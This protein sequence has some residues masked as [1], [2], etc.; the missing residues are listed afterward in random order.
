M[1]I[2]NC[3]PDKQAATTSPLTNLITGTQTGTTQTLPPN[4]APGQTPTSTTT[5]HQQQKLAQAVGYPDDEDEKDWANTLPE[6]EI[7][8]HSEKDK[9]EARTIG[10][11]K[12]PTRKEIIYD[13]D[14]D[15]DDDDNDDDFVAVEGRRGSANVPQSQQT[16]PFDNIRGLIEI[17]IADIAGQKLD[18]KKAARLFNQLFGDN[19][20]HQIITRPD[21]TMETIAL[22]ML[23]DRRLIPLLLNVNQIKAELDAVEAYTRELKAGTVLT[24]PTR[25]QILRYKIHVLKD[26]TP[27]M[28]YAN[29]LG[30]GGEGEIGEYIPYTC[31]LGDTLKSIA[32][33]HP[34]LGDESKWVEIAQVNG[35]STKCFEER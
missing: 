33:R 16:K 19:T 34:A 9:F 15:D 27:L 29:T 3:R 10:E 28:V 13:T 2:Q 24:M 6:I 8:D 5:Q 35:L 26:P 23:K 11:D 21:D 30:A 7:I 31:R 14:D 32:R 1:M 4:T 25:S 17:I 22:R 12:T 20:K 18:D